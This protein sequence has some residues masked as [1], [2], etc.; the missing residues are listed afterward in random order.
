MLCYHHRIVLLKRCNWSRLINKCISRSEV[1]RH[2]QSI[3]TILDQ[4]KQIKPKISDKKEKY[5]SILQNQ[6]H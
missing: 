1:N 6:R 5:Y 4:R 2:G 3:G